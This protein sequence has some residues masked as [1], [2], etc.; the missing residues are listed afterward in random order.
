MTVLEVIQRSTEFLKN[1]GV[2]SPRLQTELLLAHLLS[3][4]RMQLY[5]NFE[6]S[7]SQSELDNFREL[8]D[9]L[10]NGKNVIKAFCEIAPLDPANGSAAAHAVA[11]VR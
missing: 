9:T 8:I 5:L 7:L 6:R 2:D 1:K 3:M 10:V 11:S 4:P